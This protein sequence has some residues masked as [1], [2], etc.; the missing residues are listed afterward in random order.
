MGSATKPRKHNSPTS[1]CVDA[2]ANLRHCPAGSKHS[3]TENETNIRLTW[4][5]RLPT[6]LRTAKN[7]WAHSTSTPNHQIKLTST[8]SQ[9]PNPHHD[10]EQRDTTR[11]KAIL[12]DT[13]E[14]NCIS[15]PRVTKYMTE[16]DAIQRDTT[17][18]CAIQRETPVC[19]QG[20]FKSLL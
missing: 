11:Y 4:F 19:C 2:T 13:W 10:T 9:P 17:R 7:N 1:F 3:T 15:D 16:H 5:A 8:F 12:R 14:S 6:E 18:Y 20:E